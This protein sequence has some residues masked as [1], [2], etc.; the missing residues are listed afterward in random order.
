MS[1]AKAWASGVFGVFAEDI[2]EVS[3]YGTGLL[4]GSAPETVQMAIARLVVGAIGFA[5]T[6]FVPNRV[7][8]Q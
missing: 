7:P 3:A 5:L 4:L 2:Y 8:P 6:Y 1:A